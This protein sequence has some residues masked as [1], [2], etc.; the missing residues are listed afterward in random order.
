MLY[1][2][3]SLTVSNL[4]ERKEAYIVELERMYELGKMGRLHKK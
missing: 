4:N 2:V 1:V 3:K